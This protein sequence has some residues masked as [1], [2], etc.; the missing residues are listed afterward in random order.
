MNYD[1]KSQ[2]AETKSREYNTISDELTQKQAQLSSISSELSALKDSS[3]H[4]RKRTNEML[5]S[6]LSGENKEGRGYRPHVHVD[7]AS[8]DQRFEFSESFLKPSFFPKAEVSDSSEYVS[9]SS[10]ISSH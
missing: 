9:N 1:Q 6:L 5:R 8:S 4:Q 10:Q 3:L 2:E 7:L